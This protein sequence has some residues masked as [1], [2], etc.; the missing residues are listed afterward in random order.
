MPVNQLNAVD[1]TRTLSLYMVHTKESLTVTYK[2][3]GRYIPSALRQLNHFLR[4]WRRNEVIKI[5]PEVIDLVWE[6]HQELGSKK[7]VHVICG[8][9]NEATNAMLRKIGRNVARKSMHSR[10]QAMDIYFPDVPTKKLRNSALVRQIGGVG[11]YPR[12][13]PLGF[14][15][16]DTGRVRHWP[17]IP[18]Q[19]FAAIM[20]NA[21]RG[22]QKRS[23][24]VMTAEDEDGTQS[25]GTLASLI[26]KLTGSSQSTQLATPVTAPIQSA[27]ADIAETAPAAE[28]AKPESAPAKSAVVP[29]VPLPRSKPKLAT[30][31][32]AE[33][34]PQPVET[35]VAQSAPAEPAPAPAASGAPAEPAVPVVPTAKPDAAPSGPISTPTISASVKPQSSQPGSVQVEP[36]SAPPPERQSFARPFSGEGKT[37]LGSGGHPMTGAMS[38]PLGIGAVQASVT[39][40][41][42]WK[43]Q[44]LKFSLK[45]HFFNSNASKELGLNEPATTSTVTLEAPTAEK[46]EFSFLPPVLSE[47]TRLFLPFDPET[48]PVT[49]DGQAQSGGP[50]I[51]RA[52]KGN[53]LMSRHQQTTING[54]AKGPRMDSYAVDLSQPNPMVTMARMRSDEPQPLSFQE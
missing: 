46:G 15:H 43:E 53:L 54:A 36:A 26:S 28:E 10:G 20:K 29:D 34:A 13:G 19:E 4:D 47:L 39:P 40:E 11:Y 18:K 16:V 3:D 23:E 21:P 27:P 9:R 1:D 48:V 32:P 42:F 17:A 5:D 38:R 45:P 49:D 25:T 35:T 33:P 37:S 7:P 52:D 44:N 8:Y 12:S 31:E 50:V 2:K 14:V 30:P 22:P 24:P 41:A 6:L 51:N